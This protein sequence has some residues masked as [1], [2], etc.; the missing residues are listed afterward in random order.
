[1]GLL[2][3]SELTKDFLLL[4][5]LIVCFGWWVKL[6][7]TTLLA[8]AGSYIHVISAINPGVLGV[9]KLEWCS[10]STFL[11]DLT[12]PHKTLRLVRLGL[13]VKVLLVHQVQEVWVV[14]CVLVQLVLSFTRLGRAG[15]YL[16]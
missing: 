9:N 10:K 2:V 13:I 11:G 7:Q 14:V 15:K 6:R 3:I 12:G 5:D 4:D 16:G 1:L 8:R